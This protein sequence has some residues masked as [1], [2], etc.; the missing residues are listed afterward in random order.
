MYSALLYFY[1][2]VPSFKSLGIFGKIINRSLALCI[3][4]LFDATMTCYYRRTSDK[5]GFSL[6]TQKRD[7]L[8]IVSLTSFP[9]R[10]NEVW[11]TIEGILRQS[12]KADKVILWLS[13]EQFPDEVVPE[14]LTQLTKRGLTIQFCD[15]DLRSHKKYK[16]ALEMYPNDYVITL[17]DDLYYDPNL[18]QNLIKIKNEYPNAIATNRAHGIKFGENN[19]PLPYRQWEHNYT[20]LEPSNS[21]VQTGGF[22]TIYCK[23]DL[24]E[25]FNNVELIKELSFHADDLWLK[26]MV[27]L[28]DK[29]VVTNSK[30]NKDPITVKSSQIEKLVTTNVI[31]GGNDTQ[32]SKMMEYYD[33]EASRFK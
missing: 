16:Y 29:K 20:G 2:K 15:G 14:S 23:S 27:F 31:E 24:H 32:F 18:L 21:L 13:K 19:E 30:Y 33:I 8:Y 5:I 1:Y 7:K 17:D 11:I 12:F 26:I 4:I 22:G 6:N 10:I 28:K 3:K 25:D 9:A